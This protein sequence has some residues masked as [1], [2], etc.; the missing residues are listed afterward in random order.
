MIPTSEVTCPSCGTVSHF[1]QM[2]R[3]AQEFCRRCDYPLFWVRTSDAPLGDSSEGDVGLRRLPGAGGRQVVASLGCPS[4]NEPNLY[5]AT[6]CI[7]CGADLHPAPAMPVAA[8]PPPPAPV[9]EPP[10]PEPE[11]GPLWPYYALLIGAPVA[12]AL[13]FVVLIH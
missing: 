5:S 6:V 1:D 9:L 12:I 3:D 4:C 2:R 7:R 13:I 8:A 10:P 11:V